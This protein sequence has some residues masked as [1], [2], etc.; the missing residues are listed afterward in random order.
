MNNIIQILIKLLDFFSPWLELL[1]LILTLIS[2]Y[3]NVPKFL[4]LWETRNLRKIW[5]FRDKDFVTII[6]SELDEPE[7]RQNLE[8]REYIYNLKYGDLDAFF[9]VVITLLRLYPKIKLKILSSGE[10]EISK[11]D[12][13]QNLVLIGG[14]DYNAVTK[15]ILDTK[16]TIFYYKSIYNESVS[17]KYP[18]EIV[19]CHRIRDIEYCEEDD[20]KDFGYFERLSNPFNPKKKIIILGGCHTIG[21]TSAIKSLSLFNNELG[22]ISNNVI[23]NSKKVSKQINRSS[24]F[25]ILINGIKFGQSINI[26]IINTNNVFIKLQ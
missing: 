15:S 9:E 18:N 8:P 17:K 22:Q 26:P 14:P 3:K 2:I 6:C 12:L 13:S 1:L 4:K 19:I 5:G 20:T 10:A 24:Q 16:K 23:E 21:V 25:A 7:E 11:L